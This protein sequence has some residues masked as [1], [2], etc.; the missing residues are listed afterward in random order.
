L[1]YDDKE[2][3]LKGNGAAVGADNAESEYDQNGIERNVLER[4]GRR[5]RVQARKEPAFGGGLR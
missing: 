1:I 2:R 3:A 4:G 5:R